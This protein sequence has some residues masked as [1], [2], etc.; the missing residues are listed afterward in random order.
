MD[1]SGHFIVATTVGAEKDFNVRRLRGGV[2]LARWAM[3]TYSHFM[4]AMIAWKQ[5]RT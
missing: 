5:K 2:D 4:V 1:I 3:D